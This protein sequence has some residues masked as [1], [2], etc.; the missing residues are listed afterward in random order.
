MDL[1]ILLAAFGLVFLAELG[2]K[3]QL[4]A[5][6][7]T[8]SS[9]SPLMV[10]IGTCLALIC[11][12]ALAV[13]FGTLLTRFVPQQI[14]QMISAVLFVLI[15]L[16][17]LVNIAR[18]APIEEEKEKAAAMTESASASPTAGRGIVTAFIVEQ[19]S[20]VEA[21]IVHYLDELISNLEDDKDIATVETI[22]S[23]DQE[24]INSLHRIADI[25]RKKKKTSDNKTTVDSLLPDIASITGKAEEIN[26][27]QED[28]KTTSVEDSIRKAVEI[29]EAASEFYL[30][31][32]RMSKIHAARDTFRDLAME[33][34]RHAQTLCSL[35]NP[36]E[37]A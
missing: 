36:D 32:A 2:D 8:T 37:T 11:T 1:K 31:L 27:E 25:K 5:L 6:A 9:R 16:F 7:F 4:T 33:D 21:E 35:I 15:G 24:H 30:A 23:E 34:I 13:A 14:L 10:F 17:L 29:E 19:A 12:T 18:K 26:H 3:T 28:D 22:K 20:Q